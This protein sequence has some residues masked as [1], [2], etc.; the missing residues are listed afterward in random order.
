MVL[1]LFLVLLNVSGSAVSLWLLLVWALS[2]ASGL[3]GVMA[4]VW[5]PGWI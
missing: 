1:V 2:V 5:G 3:V 4:L